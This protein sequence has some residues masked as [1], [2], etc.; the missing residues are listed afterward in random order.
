MYNSNTD[1]LGLILGVEVFFSIGHCSGA[2]WSVFWAWR[3][4][5]HGRTSDPL[6]VLM[7]F[8]AMT[9]SSWL[10]L[11]VL[12]RPMAN[13]SPP[14]AFLRTQLP[15][16]T[17]ACCCCAGR[18]A[19]YRYNLHIDTNSW[20]KT[21]FCAARSFISFVN[22]FSAWRWWGPRMVVSS[23]QQWSCRYFAPQHRTSQ[24]TIDMK[25]LI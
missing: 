11:V 4:S 9:G 25:L 13:W 5:F 17:I 10:L 3:R 20:Y 2:L 24:R 21:V 1:S 22:C 23:R 6:A 15:L 16:E 18:Y 8:L 19:Q 14:A 7:L 12:C